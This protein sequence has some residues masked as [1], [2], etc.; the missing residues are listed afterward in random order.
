MSKNSIVFVIPYFG[1]FPNYF[2]F[3]LDSCRFNSSIDWIIFTDDHSDFDIPNNVHFNYISFSDLKKKFNEKLGFEVTLDNPYKLTDFKPSY[4][5][6]FHEFIENYDFWGFCDV[7]LIFGDIRKFITDDIL[8]SNDKILANGHFQLL[9]N[10][11]RCNELFMQP[12][13]GD[14]IYKDVYT[15]SN[16]RGFDEYGTKA[17]HSICEKSN[18]KIYINNLLFADINSWFK[19]FSLTFV[20]QL[21]LS[22][23]LAEV[24]H[25]KENNNSSSIFSFDRGNLYRLYLDCNGILNSSEYMYVHFQKRKMT[26]DNRLMLNSNNVSFFMVPNKFIPT[27]K[28]VSCDDIKRLGKKNIFSRRRLKRQVYITVRM[29]VK[30]NLGI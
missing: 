9:R 29:W 7:D 20:R 6:I 1:K 25:I 4:G 23:E 10:T 22:S 12:L 17:F 28:D 27:I 8:N 15:D 30:N 5:Y 2:Q 26:V 14:V 11:K 18:E 21:L 3:W 13:D 19:H 16:H 24:E